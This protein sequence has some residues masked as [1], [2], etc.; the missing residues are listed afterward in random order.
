[1]IGG[2]PID[3]AL[4]ARLVAAQFPQWKDE[5]IRPVE[6]G[7]WDNR[8]F[9][10]GAQMAVRLPS[11][12]IYAQQVEKEQRWLPKLAPHLPLP[13]P[14]PV[15][16][17]VPAGGYPWPWSVYPW[18]EGETAAWERI[19]DVPSFARALAEFLVALQ[20]IDAAEGPRPGS[21]NF[22]R[23]GPLTHYDAETRQAIAALGGRIDT[24]GAIAVW[25]ADR[26][27]VV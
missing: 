25:N 12:A 2:P 14:V 10:L 16:L 20:R 17:G 24:A 5:P 26:K 11:A 9:R 4:V 23:G 8:T 1:M 22:F 15:A 7:G 18:L 21:H 13:I 3:A 27:S 6:P 19:A